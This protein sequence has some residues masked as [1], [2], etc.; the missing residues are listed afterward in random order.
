[1]A[2]QNDKE[3]SCGHSYIFPKKKYKHMQKKQKYLSEKI[4]P[5]L[6]PSTKEIG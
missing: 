2:S 4:L 6:I 1:V 5:I 3:Y